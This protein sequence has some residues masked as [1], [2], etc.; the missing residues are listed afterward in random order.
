MFKTN[1]DNLGLS[2]GSI[3]KVCKL[4]SCLLKYDPN[5]RINLDDV[6]SYLL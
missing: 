5:K 1:Y 6:F 4:M 2:K 3:N